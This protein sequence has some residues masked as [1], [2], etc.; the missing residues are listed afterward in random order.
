MDDPASTYLDAAADGDLRLDVV[1][2]LWW[3]RA[4]G[5]EQVADLVGRREALTAGRFRATR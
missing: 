5:V 3:E 2:A 4:L 1:G